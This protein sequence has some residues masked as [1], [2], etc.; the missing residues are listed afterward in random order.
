MFM[1]D[2]IARKRTINDV[3]KDRTED[4]KIHL[5]TPKYCLDSTTLHALCV[6]KEILNGNRVE[7]AIPET[8]QNW[9]ETASNLAPKD[10]SERIQSAFLSLNFQANQEDPSS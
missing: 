4:N 5:A 3:N 9:F 1:T 10:V 8:F 2:Y 7:E 6:I